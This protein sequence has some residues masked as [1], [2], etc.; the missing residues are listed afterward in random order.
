MTEAL[1]PCNQHD[2]SCTKLGRFFMCKDAGKMNSMVS[3][4]PKYVSVIIVSFLFLI[5]AAQNNALEPSQIMS[6]PT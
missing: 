3:S 6:R 1:R 5:F 2:I 4:G